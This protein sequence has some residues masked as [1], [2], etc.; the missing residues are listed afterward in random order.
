MKINTRFEPPGEDTR[1]YLK[2]LHERLNRLIIEIERS[3]GP[4][5]IIQ[6]HKLSA[7]QASPPLP[8][9]PFNVL[10]GEFVT[11]RPSA[12]EVNAAKDRWLWFVYKEIPEE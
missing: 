11:E 4:T 12:V 10:L 2:E 7:P 9:F 8:E 1:S 6:Q 5:T 3:S